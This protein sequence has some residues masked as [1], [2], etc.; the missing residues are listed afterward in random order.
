MRVGIVALCTIWLAG[1][2]A[3]A[4]DAPF[5]PDSVNV[6]S[7]FADDVEAAHYQRWVFDLPCAS[8]TVRATFHI[9]KAYAD[10]KWAPAVKLSLNQ[11]AANAT[12]ID[13]HEER[14]SLALSRPYT[15]E[16]FKILFERD[17]TRNVQERAYYGAAD[18]EGKVFPVSI[19]WSDGTF[20]ATVAGQKLKTIRME[21]GPLSVTFT[22]SGV[23]GEFG[24][25]QIGHSGA[26]ASCA[27]PAPP[28][29]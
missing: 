19:A 25:I 9:D 16:P 11:W 3:H 4:D 20:T 10:P 14:V 23:Q 5:T 27:A 8:N 26:P 24:E 28:A 1:T 13:P 22:L 2:A 6:P 18:L 12:D 17:D 29:P 15:E 21:H 7:K